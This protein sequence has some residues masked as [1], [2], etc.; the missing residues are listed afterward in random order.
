MVMAA[1]TFGFLAAVVSCAAFAA[2]L[3]PGRCARPYA[4]EA[5][6][7]QGDLVGQTQDEPRALR[8]RR[9]FAWLQS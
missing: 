4:E 3:E 6:L 7:C 5:F 2:G 8:F 1:R 9:E